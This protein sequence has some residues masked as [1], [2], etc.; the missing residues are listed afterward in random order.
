MNPQGGGR[1][2]LEGGAIKTSK[3]NSDLLR[4]GVGLGEYRTGL[5]NGS[6]TMIG[7]KKMQSGGSRGCLNTRE[8][9][10]EG[11]GVGH[12]GGGGNGQD[13]QHVERALLGRG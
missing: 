5:L 7:C 4:K 12:D 10:N 3:I 8:T 2:C 13:R 9:Q 1:D 11:G 6:M